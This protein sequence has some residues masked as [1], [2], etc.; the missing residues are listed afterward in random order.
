MLVG[1]HLDWTG[2]RLISP[3]PA[4]RSFKPTYLI[5]LRCSAGQQSYTITDGLD[6]GI[7][8]VTQGSP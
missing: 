2:K 6:Q 1:Q 7:G 5:G 8:M 4:S 3:D